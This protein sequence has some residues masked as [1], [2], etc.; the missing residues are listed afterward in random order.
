MEVEGTVMSDKEK[1]VELLMQL[2]DNLCDDCGREPVGCAVVAI[3]DHLIAHGVM[4]QEWISV[5]DKFPEIVSTHKRYRSTIKKSVRVLCV[6]V[7]KSGKTMVKEGYC[8]WYNDYPEPRWQI[9]RTID[10]VTHWAYL[11]Q[12][13][14]GE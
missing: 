8:E 3:A 5:K 2:E 7:Q 10:E 14:K 13:P 12:P 11:P 6:C 9:P 4:V 1:L